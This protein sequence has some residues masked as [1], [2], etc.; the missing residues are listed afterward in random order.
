MKA[1]SKYFLV[2]ICLCIFNVNNIN[3]QGVIVVIAGT[4]ISQYIGDGYPATGFSLAFPKSICI[5][6]KGKIYVADY[7]NDRIRTLYHDTLNTIV[8]TLSLGGDSG[9]GGLA[10]TAK[11]DDPDGVCLDTAGNIYI[12][13]WYNDLIRKVDAKTGIISTICGIVGG[14]FG[15]DG[16]LA[17]TARINS[18]GSSC[19]DIAGNVYIPDYNNQRIRKINI[20]SGYINTIAGTGV[21]G[22]SGD[23]GL[24][25]NATLSY[26]NSI[27]VDTSGNVYFSEHGNNTIRRIDAVTGIINTIAGTGTEG[28]SGDGSLAIHA[29]LADPSGIFID[30]YNY[31]YLADHN[32]NVVRVITPAG[33][34]YTIAGTGGYGYTG[35][36]GPPLNATFR[37]PTAVCTDDSGYV[38]IADGNNSVIWKMTPVDTLHLGIKEIVKPSFNIYPNPST[39]MFSVIS[40]QQ[41][42]AADIR[43]INTLEQCVYNT[44]FAG[45]RI[46]INLSGYPAGMYFV[47]F[48]SAD[49]NVTEKIIIQ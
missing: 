23:S 46:D 24:A 29:E 41:T 45:K 35:N 11:L 22:Y 10:D 44:S 15:G 6:K 34:I 2:S 28:Y 37:G 9:D 16:G 26:P 19:T 5:D 38:Y 42:G 47:Q 43:V 30:K 40:G 21:N 27:C 4:G 31:I 32:N 39:G 49:N 48:I 33:I 18:P 14:G 1:F 25:T 12:T 7:A 8:D 36:G 13:E 20:A 3:A 17:D